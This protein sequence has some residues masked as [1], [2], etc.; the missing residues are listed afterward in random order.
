MIAE[1]RFRAKN[2]LLFTYIHQFDL[3]WFISIKIVLRTKI[4]G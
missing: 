4:V 2:K 1:N 3:L